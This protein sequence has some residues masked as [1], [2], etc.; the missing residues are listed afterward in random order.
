MPRNRT[1]IF[2]TIRT[3]GGLLPA[4]LLA[5]VAALDKNIPGL[6]PGDYHL[7]KGESLTNTIAE[8]WA[9][10]RPVW[11]TFVDALAVLPAEDAGTTLTRERWLLRLFSELGYGRLQTAKAEEIDG[12]TF[13]ISHEWANTPI[14]LVSARLPLDRRTAGVKGA[15]GASPHSL[16]QDYLN[17]STGHL[18]G[19]VSN[20]LTLRVLR[21]NASLT[22][23]AYIEFDLE[24]MFADEVFDDFV[25]LW[26]TCHQSRVEAEIVAGL[27][28]QDIATAR[29]R[30][31]AD[32]RAGVRLA[33]RADAEPD[34]VGRDGLEL[35]RK[36]RHR[37][38]GQVHHVAGKDERQPEGGR[39]G[40]LS[41][42][43]TL[44]H[45]ALDPARG[46]YS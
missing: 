9:K 12:K 8:S 29:A 20:G 21:D 3:E 5:G 19:F 24:T 7:A 42:G 43:G 31:N 27:E 17:R 2:T 38:V 10:L 32:E 16:V 44:N 41:G 28:K 23:Q 34:H 26:L 37:P 1:T 13:P 33:Q 15:A 22:R 18:W 14:H 6:A 25:V 39:C 46:P 40:R 45:E 4:D 35:G 11:K 36:P 30:G